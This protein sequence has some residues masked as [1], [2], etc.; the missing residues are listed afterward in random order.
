MVDTFPYLGSLI[1]EDG[2]CTTEFR[3][4][5]N[6]GQAIEASLHKIWKSHNIPISTKLCRHLSAAVIG[7]TILKNPV[8]NS[9]HQSTCD[10]AAHSAEDRVG[11]QSGFADVQSPQHIDAVVG[12]PASPNPGSRTWPQPACDRSLRH[13]FTTTTFALFDALRHLSG[14]HYRK[15]FSLVTLLQFLSLG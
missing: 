6:R 12:L 3:T 11:L 4:R 8:N 10:T 5:L 13:P 2:E 7:P 9:V 1:T 15:L 14:T